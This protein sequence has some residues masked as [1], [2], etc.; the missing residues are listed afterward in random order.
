M[1]VFLRAPWDRLISQFSIGQ[2]REITTFEKFTRDGTDSISRMVGDL[3]QYFFVG[4][5]EH[6]EESMKMLEWYAGIQFN[7]P[8]EYKNHHK[9]EKYRPTKE[10]KQVF[11][12]SNEK[13]IK[14]YDQARVR[15]YTQRRE[16]YEAKQKESKEALFARQL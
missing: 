9:R 3:E 13:D 2:H 15:F 6:F 14:L 16:Y 7:W 8:L 5:Q 12:Q 11:L 4:L 10:D 1:F